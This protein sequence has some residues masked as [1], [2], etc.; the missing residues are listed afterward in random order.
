MKFKKVPNDYLFSKYVREDGKYIIES[1]DRKIN[2]TWKNVFIVTDENGKE[3]EVFRRLKDAKEKYAVEEV[4]EVVED[5]KE[6]KKMTVKE[7]RV[8]AKE[9]GI[10]GYSR[11]SK[12]DLRAAIESKKS[13]ESEEI[14]IK[15]Y[16]F[17]GMYIG[18]FK[19]KVE[20]GVVVVDT[21]RK[22]ELKFKDGLEITDES[23]ARWANRIEVA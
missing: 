6:E 21:K 15:M 3:I 18:E 4:E 9:L 19:A 23:K 5:K 8:E 10:K 17:T 2:G 22:G 12:E 16:A 13:S 14:T 20:D 7:M 11:M 1:E